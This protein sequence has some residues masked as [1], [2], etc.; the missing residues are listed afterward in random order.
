MIA[1]EFA[2]GNDF[3]RIDYATWRKAVEAELKGAPFEKKMV[4]RTYESIDLQPI[5]TE[6]KFATSV[7]PAGMPGFAPFARGAQVLGNALAGW[8]IRQEHAEP[9]P[10]ELN[11]EILDDLR[12]GVSSIVLRLDAASSAGYDADDPNSVELSGRDGVMISTAADVQR[13]LDQMHLDIAG[14]GLEAGGA[15][16]SA[17]ALYVTAARLAGVEPERLL[18][19]F[20]ADPLGTLMR[21]GA[22]PVPLDAALKQMA[23][24][25][26]W[27]GAHAP[28]MTAVEVSTAPYHHAGATTTQDL[29]FLLG[30]GVEYL[31]ALTA[32]G[33][34]V[35][36]AAKQIAFSVSIGCRFYQAIAK[37]RAARMLWAHLAA[38]CGGDAAAQTMRLRVTTSRRVQTTRNPALNILRNTAACY[39]GAIAGA[40]AITT[41]P[42]DAPVVLSTELSR[43]NARNIQLVLAE[44][45]H[46]NRVV[47][48]AGGSW[49][50]EWY[51]RQL[52]EKAWALFQQI[53]TQGGMV[54]AASGGW[55]A[56][57]IDTVELKREHDVATRKLPITGIS[58]HP[59]ISEKKKLGE[60]APRR[61]ELMTAA[62]QG[63]ANWRKTH[64]PQPDLEL[65]ADAARRSDVPAGELTARAIAAAGAGATLGQMA[66]ALHPPGAEPVQ[67]VALAEHPFDEAF[68]AL[69]DASDAFAAQHGHRPRV[70][71]AGVGSI[72]EQIGRKTYA[73]NFFEAGG[74]EVLARETKCD[75][76]ASAAAFAQSGAKIA[77]ICSTDKQYATCVAQLAPKLKQAGARTVVLAGNPGAREAAYRAARVDRFIF[78]KCDVLETLSSLLRD[79]G[80]L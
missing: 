25:A 37:I 72:A 23:D 45:C 77:V 6:E 9:D 33:L 51:T 74:F 32:G 57:Q 35:N 70:F 21:E 53:E 36:A 66:A 65:L 27:T 43:R 59:D 17:A 15:F 73:K 4:S 58:E 69:R 10:A 68:E 75:V 56:Q 67:I 24:L 47:D 22:L 30:T 52:A 39:A 1:K 2:L 55:V 34:D 20:N 79:E 8:D 80:A 26:A 76:D 46:L 13:A 71:L 61:V 14:V 78:L 19:A 64:A 49:Y 60:A 44:E 16:L 42:F 41:V 62:A 5:Y 48:P 28:H 31:R 38:S 18:G 63:L 40:D 50:I 12:N 11:A 3:P 54:A 7:D 29:A